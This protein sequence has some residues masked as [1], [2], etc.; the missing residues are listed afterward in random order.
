VKRFFLLPILFLLGLAMPAH[1]QF[2]RI[3]SIQLLN[4]NN[5][6]A[7]SFQSN[8]SFKV[9]TH[10]TWSVTGTVATLDC[11]GA[12]TS[13]GGS[14]GNLQFNNAGS[15]GGVNQTTSNVADCDG[16][17]DPCDIRFTGSATFTYF[18]AGTNTGASA[19]NYF[20]C[21]NYTDAGVYC[22]ASDTT[23]NANLAWSPVSGSTTMNVLHAGKLTGFDIEQ[24]D[25]VITIG[26]L[27]FG[28]SYTTSPTAMSFALG[29]GWGSTASAGTV[30]GSDN[31]FI[32]TITAGGTGIAANPTITYTYADGDFSTAS[33]S[34]PI[35][36]CQ[37]T[38][39]ND[40][41]AD[42]TNTPTQT[43]LAMTWRGTPTTAKT[44]TI[45]CHLFQRS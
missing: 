16:A 38:G 19:G 3:I 2:S 5:T 31:S 42:I 32:F 1:A 34:T 18:L 28:A 10:C 22:N 13:P 12:G 41:I 15:F 26:R 11:T 30:G 45:S 37:Q 7:Q 40:I 33:A 24:T 9:G 39:G 17:G 27:A 36:L 14:S 21:Y 4:N 35:A 43:S 44:Y 25:R 23:D 6:V 20:A 8:F 29:T